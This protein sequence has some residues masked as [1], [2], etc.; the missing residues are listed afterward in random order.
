MRGLNIYSYSPAQII[1]VVSCAGVKKG[2]MRPDKVFL[3]SVLAGC[4][5]S[6]A[7]ATSLSMN[8]APWYQ[9]NAVGFIHTIGAMVFPY[10]FVLIVLTGADL[11]TSTF[12]VSMICFPFRTFCVARDEL[13]D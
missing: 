8:A 5:L 1:E 9:Q 11:C 13:A 2:M 10:G 6:F 4:L 12:M 3:S 7:A